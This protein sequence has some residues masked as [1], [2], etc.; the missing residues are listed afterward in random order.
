MLT[1]D[2]KRNWKKRLDIKFFIS[3]KTHRDLTVSN[4]LL[5]NNKNPKISDFVALFI[6]LFS[7]DVFARSFIIFVL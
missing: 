1:D 2:K 6:Y 4:I 3:T 5:D 7:M